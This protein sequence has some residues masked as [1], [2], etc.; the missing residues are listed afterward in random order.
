LADT[1]NEPPINRTIELYIPSELGWERTA[2]E[3]AAS[4]AKLMGFPAERIEDIKTAVSEATINAIEHGNSLDASQ[5]VLIILVPE[6]QSLEINV[7]DRS[8]TPF[9]PTDSSDAPNLDDKL[10]GL[11]KTRGWGTFLIKSLMDEVEFTSGSEGNLVRMV[12]H[13]ER[14]DEVGSRQ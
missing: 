7:H 8:S 11:S 3:A 14:R 9:E 5:K 2:M 10:A 13:L 6:G 12:I 1:T 4:V